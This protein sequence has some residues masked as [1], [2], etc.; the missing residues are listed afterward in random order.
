MEITR[1][2]L[3]VGQMQSVQIWKALFG[4]VNWVHWVVLEIKLF[5][6][7][8]ACELAKL[9]TIIGYIEVGK[10]LEELKIL[11]SDI[12]DIHAS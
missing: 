4:K 7:G 12:V 9:N 10:A 8:E 11:L 2:D 3:I 6:G 5:Q 1:W